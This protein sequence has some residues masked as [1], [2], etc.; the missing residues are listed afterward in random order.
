MVKNPPADA[1]HSGN[2][3]HGFDPWVRKIPWRSARQPTPVFL[4]GETHGQRSLVCYCPQ[5]PKSQTQLKQ[6]STEGIF[7]FFFQFLSLL[8]DSFMEQ[9]ISQQTFLEPLLLTIHFSNNCL[10]YKLLGYQCSACYNSKQG[11]FIPVKQLKS[12][13]SRFWLSSQAFEMP[14]SF[15]LTFRPERGGWRTTAA[16]QNLPRPAQVLH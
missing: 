13:F 4:P 12:E 5:G 1:G 3:K 11:Q 7:F 14:V 9:T 2:R 8:Q 6:L 15:P 16:P 10:N